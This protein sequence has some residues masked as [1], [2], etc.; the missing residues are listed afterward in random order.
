LGN[1]LQESF[2]KD[3]SI[4]AALPNITFSTPASIYF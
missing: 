3:L 2:K 4:I 1:L